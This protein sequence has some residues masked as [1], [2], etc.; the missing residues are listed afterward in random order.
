[1]VQAFKNF[2]ERSSAKNF[3]LVSLVS[4]V[5]EELANDKLVN[6]MKEMWPIY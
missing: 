1:M 5:F 3:R 6:H 2:G 4:K